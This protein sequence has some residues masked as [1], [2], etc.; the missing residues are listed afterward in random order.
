MY[1][2]LD[3]LHC[4]IQWKEEKKKEYPSQI[5]ARCSSG[6]PILHFHPFH[7]LHFPRL[8]F[9]DCS[10]V[11]LLT[12]TFLFSVHEDLREGDRRPTP[13]TLTEG[14]SAEENE[15]Q[16]LFCPLRCHPFVDDVLQ[17]LAIDP[18]ASLLMICFSTL[19]PRI[20]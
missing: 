2:S 1:R 14:Q 19:F 11:S 20:R 4:S 17:C 15:D 7:R 8:V 13:L 10:S 3:S 18:L 12:K 9:L 5:V 16:S 6:L